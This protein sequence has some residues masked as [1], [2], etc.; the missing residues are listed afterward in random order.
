M[1]IA[2]KASLW[3]ALALAVTLASVGIYFR[4]QHLKPLT[5]RGAVIVQ[6][7]DTRKQLPIA[8]VEVSVKDSIT[9]VVKSDSAGFFSLQLRQGLRRGRPI[10]LIFRHPDYHPLDLAEYTGDKLYIVHLVPLSKHTDNVTNRPSITVGNVRVRYST[11]AMRT[12]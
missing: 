10:T 2:R 4:R 3:I 8:G 12:G 11:K 9:Q 7:A 5:I 6:D 1:S